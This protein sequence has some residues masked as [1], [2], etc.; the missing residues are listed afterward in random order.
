M[1]TDRYPSPLSSLSSSSPSSILPSKMDELFQN[2]PNGLLHF[3][4]AACIV[5]I[6]V[7]IPGNLITI[8]ALA[9]CKKVCIYWMIL[10]LLAYGFYSLPV[11]TRIVRI[12]LKK[13]QKTLTRLQDFDGNFFYW[14]SEWFDVVLLLTAHWNS[15]GAWTSIIRSNANCCCSHTILAELME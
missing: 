7:G 12:Y 6:L 4:T 2:Y 8:I 13:H 11:L 3:A 15:S 5:F 1:L 14:I 10:N 9:R